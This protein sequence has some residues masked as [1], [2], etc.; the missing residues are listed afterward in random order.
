MMPRKPPRRTVREP[1][2]VYLAPDDRALLESLVRSS[3][4]SRAEILRRGIRSFAA[5]ASGT[6]SPMLA[7]LNEAEAGDWP[8]GIAKGHDDVLAEAHRAP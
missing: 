3:G 2:Q 4:L 7:F 8:T 1:V 5:A 6:D